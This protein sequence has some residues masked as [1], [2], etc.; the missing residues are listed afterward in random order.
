MVP[1]AQK[2]NSSRAGARQPKRFDARTAGETIGEALFSES[3]QVHVHEVLSEYS[4]ADPNVPT[5]KVI[6]G[7]T[8]LPVRGQSGTRIGT[9][10]AKLLL[11]KKLFNHVTIKTRPVA[12]SRSP[13]EARARA[14]AS[15]VSA[16][17]ESTSLVQLGART[18]AGHEFLAALVVQA[19]AHGH[20]VSPPKPRR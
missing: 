20:V 4:A 14:A 10:L 17:V 18:R 19:I 15:A 8:L 11:T 2:P 3:P 7:V 13:A 12:V 1:K 9:Q 6:S 5:R 16:P